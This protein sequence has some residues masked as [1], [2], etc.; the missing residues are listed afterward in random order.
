MVV[1]FL[2]NAHQG[3]SKKVK[4]VKAILIKRGIVKSVVMGE[5]AE[6]FANDPEVAKV[7]GCQ[8]IKAF[9]GGDSG[10]EDGEDD[11]EG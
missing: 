3:S 6:E 8:L 2:I 4:G 9:D 11:E 10:S 5:V 1:Y 7:R